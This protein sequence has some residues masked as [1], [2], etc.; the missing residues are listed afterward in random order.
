IIHLATAVWPL[1]ELARSFQFGVPTSLNSLSLV[2]CLLGQKI[3]MC[4]T[5]CALYLQVHSGLAPRTL[6][7]VR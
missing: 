4:F 7:L 1:L 2:C 6:L 3:R 5:V